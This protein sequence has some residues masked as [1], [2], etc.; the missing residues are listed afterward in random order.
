MNMRLQSTATVFFSY[1]KLVLVFVDFLVTRHSNFH[2]PDCTAFM[3]VFSLVIGS[4]A[5]S[6]C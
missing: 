1:G 6:L 5:Y 3:R 4:R 2:F